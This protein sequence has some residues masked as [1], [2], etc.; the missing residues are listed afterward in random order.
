[1]REVQFRRTFG[2]SH[3]NYLDEPMVNAQWMV[4]VANLMDEVANRPQKS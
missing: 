1:M 4:I 2:G 3:E